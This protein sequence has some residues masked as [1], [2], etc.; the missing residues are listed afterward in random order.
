MCAARLDLMRDIF[1]PL[2]RDA[3]P[4]VRDKLLSIV[5]TTLQSANDKLDALLRDHTPAVSAYGPKSAAAL[6]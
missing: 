6:P 4:R 2:V 1:A 3:E 5:K